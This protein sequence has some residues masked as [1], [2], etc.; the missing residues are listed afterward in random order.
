MIARRESLGIKLGLIFRLH[1]P[2]ANVAA[3]VVQI[4]MSGSVGQ[5]DHRVNFADG[6]TKQT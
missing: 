2:L 1:L 4:A 3:M 6:G 5:I